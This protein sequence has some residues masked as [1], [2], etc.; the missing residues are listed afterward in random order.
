MTGIFF[1]FVKVLNTKLV[2]LLIKYHIDYIIM[3]NF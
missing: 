2:I 1:L 3:I